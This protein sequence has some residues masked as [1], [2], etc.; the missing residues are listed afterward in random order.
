MQT[1]SHIVIEFLAKYDLNKIMKCLVTCK[2][3]EREI[4]LMCVMKSKGRP[5]KLKPHADI[6]SVS[7]P[8]KIALLHQ[9]YD[10]YVH[11]LMLMRVASFGAKRKSTAKY[12]FMKKKKNVVFSAP[13]GCNLI[14]D[15]YVDLSFVFDELSGNK[16]QISDRNVAH[17][18]GCSFMHAYNP[19]VQW[20]LALNLA[21]VRRE[22]FFTRVSTL[23]VSRFA[24]LDKSTVFNVYFLLAAFLNTVAEVL[25][26]SCLKSLYE[27]TIAH[28]DASFT[29]FNFVHK[30][31]YFTLQTDAPSSPDA[32]LTP[33]SIPR[34]LLLID[35][36]GLHEFC[37]RWSA[38]VQDMPAAYRKLC[39]G[40]EKH[41][42]IALELITLFK[43]F[44]EVLLVLE[45]F[46]HRLVRRES[47]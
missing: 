4:L 33:N 47:K 8:H 27:Y 18:K 40:A 32:S 42:L 17:I 20:L 41:K 16:V 15:V 11:K 7:I 30:L 13:P 46:Q 36:R 43:H 34:G 14:G 19:K 28:L 31:Q 21:Y 6:D 24:A 37:A 5:H 1:D 29:C 39:A 38:F 23:D 10:T 35:K 3:T 12:S 25:P 26:N 22:S 9:L 45:G 2:S 44:A